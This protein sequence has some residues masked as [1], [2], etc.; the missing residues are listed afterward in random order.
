MPSFVQV[1]DRDLRRSIKRVV[2]VL[3]RPSKVYRRAAIHMRDYCRTTISLQGR[4]Q[5]WQPLSDWTKKKAGKR[6]ALLA[7][8]ALIK[9]KAD[10]KAGIVY[11]TRSS[12]KWHPDQHHLGFTSPPVTNK[13][14]VIKNSNG[15]IIKFLRSRGASRIPARPYWPQRSEVEREIAPIFKDWMDSVA[16]LKWS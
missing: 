6:K 14:M 2:D 9:A 13:R 5:K 4:V 10:N 3:K 15:G 11:I 16:R 1:E 12:T 8:R 7:I